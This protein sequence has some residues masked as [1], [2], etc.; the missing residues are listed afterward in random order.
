M[1]RKP[2]TTQKELERLYKNGERDLSKLHKTKIFY[3]SEEIQ[4]MAYCV[5]C[6][7]LKKNCE[8]ELDPS[9]VN[10]DTLTA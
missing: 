10:E 2:T 8:C 1:K 6:D 7:R 5:S 9:I 4:R 3:T